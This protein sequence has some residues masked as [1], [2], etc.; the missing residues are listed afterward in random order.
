MFEGLKDLNSSSSSPEE[1]AIK[2]LKRS[3]WFKDLPDDVAAD[4]AAKVNLLNFEEN[5][6]LLQK[7]DEGD[8]VFIIKDGWVKIVI[9]EEKEEDVVLNHLGPGEFIGELSLID[10]RPREASVVAITAVDA[11]ELKRTDFLDLLNS[12]PQLALYV[13]HNISDRMRFSLNF[14]EQAIHWSYRIAEG[15]YSEALAEINKIQNT[16][17]IDNQRTQEARINRFLAAFF[18]MAEGIKA[19]EDK[20]VE[21]LYEITVQIDQAQRDKKL[22][23]LTRSEFF[24]Q[25]KEDAQRVRKERDT[26]NK[27][28]VES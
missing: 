5:A 8:S 25:L 9:D 20:L 15:D 21:Q 1:Q 26:R 27:K 3:A 24:Q 19:R 13:I 16:Q 14:V 10:Q 18:R 17:V 2:T 6:P 12:Y 28:E 11:F 4:L 23:T 7:G 22:D